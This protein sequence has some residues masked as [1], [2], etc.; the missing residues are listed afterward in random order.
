MPSCL[1]NVDTT[2]VF[3]MPENAFGSDGHDKAKCPLKAYGMCLWS[4]F[5]S[6]LTFC[7]QNK[8]EREVADVI[9]FLGKRKVEKSGETLPHLHE[10]FLYV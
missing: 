3:W 1:G 6:V 4:E 7:W 10:L 5:N 2:E 8:K 9:F